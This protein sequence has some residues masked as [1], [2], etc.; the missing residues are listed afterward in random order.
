MRAPLIF[1]SGRPSLSLAPIDN[2][3][4]ALRPPMAI[5]DLGGDVL[6]DCD[7]AAYRRP[8]GV[9]KKSR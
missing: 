8:V 5:H 6:F 7:L 2:V 3:D 1:G 4:D 9:A